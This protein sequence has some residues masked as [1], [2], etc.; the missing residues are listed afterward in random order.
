VVK[1]E[2]AKNEY[3]TKLNIISATHKAKLAKAQVDAKVQATFNARNY[4]EAISGIGA[5]FV[6]DMQQ[7]T[8]NLDQLSKNIL[9]AYASYKLSQMMCNSIYNIRSLIQNV[10][11]ELIALITKSGNLAGSAVIKSLEI[12]QAMV[13]LT[14]EKFSSV[15]NKVE[16]SEHVT[17]MQLSQTVFV[18]NQLLTVADSNLDATITE[19]LIKL[20]NSDDVLSDA[21]GRFDKFITDIENIPDWD[22]KTGVWAVDILNSS[23]APYIKFISDIGEILTSIPALAISDRNQDQKIILDL[24]K[25]IDL[26]FRMLRTHNFMVSG[27]LYSYTP[28]MDSEFGNLTRLLAN[29]GLLQGFAVTMSVIQI[30]AKLSMDLVS[31]FDDYFPLY[32]KCQQYKNDPQFSAFNDPEIAFIAEK[33]ERDIAP[34]QYHKS[35]QESNENAHDDV[36]RLKRQVSSFTINPKPQDHYGWN[37]K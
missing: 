24:M 37:A 30:I 25:K 7:I 14:Q 36:M 21:S 15:I 4:L 27:V 23:Q 10:I 16:S 13:E 5:S 29:A 17:A 34:S 9:Q 20:I 19:S 22:G 2:T 28:Y 31:N 18:G 11:N 32:D 6:F 35:V 8:D 26:T 1:V 3:S 33:K 12:S